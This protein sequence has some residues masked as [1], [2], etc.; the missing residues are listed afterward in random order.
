MMAENGKIVEN[1]EKAS[2]IRGKKPEITAF[3]L[4]TVLHFAVSFFHERWFDEGSSWQIAKKAKIKDILFSIPHYEGHPPL[5]HLVLCPFARSGAPYGLSLS[6]V[7][8]A[9]M[10]AAVFLLLFKTRLPRLV[11]LFL[12]FTYFLV[13]QYGVITRPYCMMALAFVLLALAHGERN[14]HPLKYVICLFFLCLTSAY[15]IVCAGGICVAWLAEIFSANGKKIGKLFSDRRCY[16]LLALLVLTLGMLYFML[17]AK[18]TYASF[19]TSER[20]KFPRL[21]IDLVYGLLILPADALLANTFSDSTMVLF[22]YDFNAYELAVGILMGAFILFLVYINGRRK[23]TFLYIIIPH[24]LLGIFAGTVYFYIHHIGIWLLLFLFWLIITDESE[25]KTEFP[26][27][28]K[29]TELS[30]RFGRIVVFLLLAVSVG[31]GL[32]SSVLEI[33]ETY[34]YS[35]EVV[36]FIEDKGLADYKIML[37]WFEQNDDDSFSGT[38]EKLPD[39]VFPYMSYADTLNAYAGC[40]MIYNY[41]DGDDNA[42]IHHKTSTKEEAREIA[43]RWKEAGL[44]DILIGVPDLYYVFG[45]K[46]LLEMYDAIYVGRETTIWKGMTS[47]YKDLYIYMRKDLIEKL[48]LETVPKP[49]WLF[50]G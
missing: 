11:K 25:E 47:G 33:K 35:K 26:L 32:W 41:L 9:F 13:Y 29:Y 6:V 39:Y 4:W 34:S 16:L 50:S 7:S 19:V 12:P 37:S 38:E 28:A 8:F 21:L 27:Y 49:S 17:P 5:W 24:M 20:F 10:G 22:N 15:G 46:G 40:N 3:I 2:P 1:G 48:G 30:E 44:P 31:Q 23:K 43:D 42:Y 45:E 18:D 36:E 14:R